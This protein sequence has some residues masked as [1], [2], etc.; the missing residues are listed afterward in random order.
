MIK[1]VEAPEEGATRR[2]GAHVC[3]KWGGPWGMSTDR[4]GC[5]SKRKGG[6][7]GSTKCVIVVGC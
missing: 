2:T 5:L 4:G 3:V 7:N 1:L 6:S